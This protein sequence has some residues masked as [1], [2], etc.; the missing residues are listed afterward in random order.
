[1][2]ETF[3][4]RA[5][6]AVVHAAAE[7]FG[8]RRT[9]RPD[10]EKPFAVVARPGREVT[11]RMGRV[12]VDQHVFRLRRTERVVVNLLELVLRRVDARFGSIVG[13][14]VEALG[15]GSPR[16][17][18]ELHPL[19]VVVGQL[20]RRHVDHADLHPVGTRLG[21]GIGAIIAVLGERHVGQRHRP[22]GRQGVGIEEDAAL[23]VG[24]IGAVE[25]RLVLKPVVV[26]PVPGI[27]VPGGNAL[28]G[29]VP[30]LGEALADGPAE[31][32]LREV[33]VRHGVLGGDPGGRSLRVVV[34]EP[35]VGV[36]HLRAE[37]VVD[38]LAA[39][40]VGIGLMLDLFH[41]RATCC[42]HRDD[43]HQEHGRTYRFDHVG[44][45]YLR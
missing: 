21:H 7:D 15:V 13:A 41:L 40:G 42:N 34:L 1:M 43:A 36:G 17:A 12:V 22:V 11:Q 18:R 39:R 30:E 20:A 27:A 37:V 33:V 45:G 10:N 23:G 28:L 44:K 29:V 14:V 9:L 3:Q 24:R 31:R 8:T 19:D 2:V 25:H 6:A 32:N 4:Q 5:E 26:K 35:A 38:H 16:G